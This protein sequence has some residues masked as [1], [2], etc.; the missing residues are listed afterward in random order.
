MGLRKS[1]CC[2]RG[3]RRPLQPFFLFFFNTFYNLP[4]SLF[5]HSVAADYTFCFSTTDFQFFRWNS[6]A[7]SHTF[8]DNPCFFHGSNL[9]LQRKSILLL[10]VSKDLCVNEG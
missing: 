3:F 1:G 2:P 4:V 7:A 5:S 6:R 8:V 9:F 10:N